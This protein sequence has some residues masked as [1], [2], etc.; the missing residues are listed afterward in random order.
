MPSG[1]KLRLCRKLLA[2]CFNEAKVE[3]EYIALVE[4]EASQ[5]L[6]DFA[7]EPEEFMGH[8]LRFSNSVIKS[9][10]YGTRTRHAEQLEEYKAWFD[11]YV[12]LLEVG[13]TPPVDLLPWLVHVPQGLWT[14][15]WKNWKDKSEETSRAVNAAFTQMA[16]PVLER[17]KRG[18]RAA[19]VY[20]YVLDE[21][22]KGIDLTRRDLDVFAG[23]LIDA[24]SDTTASAIRVFIQAM[25]R[26]P[27]V[28]ERAHR[29]VDEVVG[30]IRSPGWSDVASLP[31]VVQ[32]VKEVMRWRPLAALIMRSTTA[33]DTIDGY[34]IPKGTTVLMNVWAL[35][36]GPCDV[37]TCESPMSVFNP[38]RYETRTHTSAQYAASP[39]VGSRDH[40][41]FGAGRRICPGM[42]LA[43][44]SL[45]V[46]IAKLLWAFEFKEKSGKPIDIDPN[47]GFMDGIVR[48]PKDFECEIR[49]RE[50][51]EGVL[52]REFAEARDVLV[53]YEL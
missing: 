52:E 29:H 16:E 10:V 11:K 31:Y 17:R 22:E 32:I 46:A 53:K 12:A 49:V 47:T 5:M 39:D 20:D 4:A 43:E 38:D 42:H 41:T 26:Y 51:R 45:F 1:E 48:T 27:D 25:A 33:D 50:G 34:F 37:D 9:L 2:Q 30:S 13:A 36:H 28:Q 23:S 19:T 24:G 6:C 44:R 3:K 15:R 8:T 14:G 40:F 18:V 21:G 7:K 35:N